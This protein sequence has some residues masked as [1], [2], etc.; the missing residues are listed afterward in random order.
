MV[1]A[2]E[3]LPQVLVQA[4]QAAGAQVEAETLD[5]RIQAAVVVEIQQSMRLVAALAAPA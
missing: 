2:A 4:G 3:Y 1:A 5:Y